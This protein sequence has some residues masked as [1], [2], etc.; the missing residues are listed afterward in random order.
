[1]HVVQGLDTGQVDQ[2][3]LVQADLHAALAVTTVAAHQFAGIDRGA[4]YGIEYRALAAARHAHQG[5]AQ[6]TLAPEQGS[7]YGYGGFMHVFGHNL[8]LSQ[9]PVYT[10]P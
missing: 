7:R 8:F 2:A 6:A 9:N 5:H 1:M 4:G 10:S 3:G